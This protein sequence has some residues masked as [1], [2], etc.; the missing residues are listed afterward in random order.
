MARPK[1]YPE[2]STWWRAPLTPTAQRKVTAYMKRHGV[3]RTRAIAAML[4]RFV[5]KRAEG[6]G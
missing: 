2:G 3:N 4:E 1:I 5:E 6:G